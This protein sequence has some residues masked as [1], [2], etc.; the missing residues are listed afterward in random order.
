MTGPKFADFLLCSACFKDDGLR[1]ESEKV[2]SK[3]ISR[4]ANCSNLHGHKLTSENLQDLVQHFFWDGSFFRSEFGGA[5]RIVSNPY[6]YKDSDVTFAPWLSDDAELL[7]ETLEIGLFHYGPP[8]WRVGEIEP[9]KRLKSRKS[10]KKAA[11]DLIDDFPA[12]EAQPDFIFCRLR[13]GITDGKEADIS[14]YDAPPDRFLGTGR[15]DSESFPVLYGSQDLEICFH[16][17]KITLPQESFVAHIHPTRALRLLDMRAEIKNDGPTEFE[18]KNLA[19]H[20]LFSAG[21]VSYDITRSIS[22]AAAEKGYEGII[23]PSY[24]SSWKPEKIYNIAI[25]GRPISDGRLAVR[26]I[27]RAFLRQAS[28]QYRLGPVFE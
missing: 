17:C 9:L 28:Y 22:F 11:S 13:T 15:L 18:S 21:N 14:Q 8:L 3:I 16:E 1:I 20:Y 6:R 7:Q 4:C 23:Y 10:R 2:G 5:S 19:I 26:S 24:F 25:F 12:F 27:N